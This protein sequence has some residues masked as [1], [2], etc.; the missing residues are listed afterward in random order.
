MIAAATPCDRCPSPSIVRIMSMLPK[1]TVQMDILLP[2]C[3]CAKCQSS[4]Y[5]IRHMVSQNRHQGN[6]CYAP[7][8]T[9]LNSDRKYIRQTWIC[10][11]TVEVRTRSFVPNFIIF[12]I[13]A[14]IIHKSCS[15]QCVCES[16]VEQCVVMSRRLVIRDCDLFHLIKEKNINNEWHYTDILCFVVSRNGCYTKQKEIN[17]RLTP[18]VRLFLFS[19]LFLSKNAF[20]QWMQ[21]T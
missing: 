20:A 15:T 21:S 6:L 5:I 13:I 14:I 9:T 8:T 2:G 16:T 3:V 17:Y 19:S 10:V 12:A 1:R 4:A 7:T 11:T 18:V